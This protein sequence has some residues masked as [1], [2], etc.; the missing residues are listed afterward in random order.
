MGYSVVALATA[1]APKP[2]AFPPIL[3]GFGTQQAAW[4]RWEDGDEMGTRWGW[5]CDEDE[6]GDGE[7]LSSQPHQ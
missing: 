7:Q 1:S 5:G 4:G 3:R 6:D 2:P